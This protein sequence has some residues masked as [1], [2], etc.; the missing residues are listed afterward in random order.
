MIKIPDSKKHK[1]M[2][3][4]KNGAFYLSA[5]LNYY[6][7]KNKYEAYINSENKKGKKKIPCPDL[8]NEED[9]YPMEVQEED[10]Y[11]WGLKEIELLGR[12]FTP[13]FSKHE[14]LRAIKSS[15]DLGEI[16]RYIEHEE[17]HEKLTVMA[18]PIKIEKKQSKAGNEYYRLYL[19]DEYSKVSIYISLNV[20]NEYKHYIKLNEASLL[21]VDVKKGFLILK[22]IKPCQF[23]DKIKLFS[24]HFNTNDIFIERKILN[25]LKN[26]I[27]SGIEV[28]FGN[29]SCIFHVNLTYKIMKELKQN[30]I[31]FTFNHTK[32]EIPYLICGCE[33]EEDYNEAKEIFENENKI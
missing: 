1:L 21:L 28:L 12:N 13:L 29:K 14:Q 15:C 5:L 33:T 16:Y 3:K 25:I 4:N 17:T 19:V 30:N 20:Y 31:E 32:E 6:E 8:P 27:G 7:D 23:I 24:I 26:N 11:H 10:E 2:W 22:Y 9:F 18:I